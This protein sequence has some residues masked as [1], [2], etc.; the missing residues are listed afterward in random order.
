[1]W[2]VVYSIFK[3]IWQYL[4]KIH[5][6]LCKQLLCNQCLN[7][8]EKWAGYFLTVALGLTDGWC[9]SYLLHFTERHREELGQIT[10]AN[11]YR[12]KKNVLPL[13]A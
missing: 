13:G 2:K 4:H 7:Q 9:F 5:L 11:N 10:A 12:F 6:Y 3:G 1:M 8:E